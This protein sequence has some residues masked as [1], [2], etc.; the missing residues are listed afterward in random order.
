MCKVEDKSKEEIV[1]IGRKI[2]EAFAEAEKK[3]IPCV[4]DTDTPLK[5]KKYISCGMKLCGE[6]KLKHGISLYT[7]AITCRQKREA[8]YEIHRN[9]HGYVDFVFKII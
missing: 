2:G 7:M 1:K 6:K 3:N 8:V 5:V 4:L 9:A